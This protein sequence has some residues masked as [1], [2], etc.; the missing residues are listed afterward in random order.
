MD[1]PRIDLAPLDVHAD[2]LRFERTVRTLTSAIQAA[3]PS[4]LLVD[5]AGWG[6]FGL[7][8]AAAAAVVAWVAA[9]LEERPP[10]AAISTAAD[11]VQLVSQWAQA[12]AIPSDGSLYHLAGGTNDR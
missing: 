4:P 6:R 3:R 7:A 9:L 12:D 8:A 5:L 1:E 11:P 10:A 2:R